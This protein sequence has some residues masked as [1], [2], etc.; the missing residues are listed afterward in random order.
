M[1]LTVV[2]ILSNALMD[3]QVILLIEGYLVR[4]EDVK[5]ASNCPQSPRE[6]VAIGGSFIDLGSCSESEE[7]KSY[8]LEHE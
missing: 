8:F 5:P 1:K 4:V 3:I 2:D 7:G 6:D